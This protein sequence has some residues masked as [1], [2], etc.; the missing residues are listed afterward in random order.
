MLFRSEHLIP[1]GELR[2]VANT[3]FD[4]RALTVVGSRIRDGR[5][6]QIMFGR[7]YDHNFVLDGP[8]GQLNSAVRVVNPYS[9]RVMEILTTAP[10]VQFYTG[11][12]L[13]GTLTGKSGTA[14]R[15]GDAIAFEPQVFPDAPNHANFPS[16]RLDPGNTYENS[17]VYRFAVS[18]R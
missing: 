16:A 13:D 1:T 10:G 3:P 4:F 9:G 17:I 12:F 15:Q 6:S 5:D 2:S 7:G 11:N 8:R 14:Y 18:K